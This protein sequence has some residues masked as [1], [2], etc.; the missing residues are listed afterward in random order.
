MDTTNVPQILYNG[1]G[2]KSFRSPVLDS[3]EFIN[4][5][6]QIKREY[7]IEI[8]KEETIENFP[9]SLYFLDTSIY[10]Y[11]ILDNIKGI[12]KIG[13]TFKIGVDSIIKNT[14]NLI[15]SIHNVDN[16]KSEILTFRDYTTRNAPLLRNFTNELNTIH[17]KK[18]IAS[19]VFLSPYIFLEL[20]KND[21]GSYLTNMKSISDSYSEIIKL[22]GDNFSLKNEKRQFDC[23]LSVVLNYY[24]LIYERKRNIDS[25]IDFKLEFLFYRNVMKYF[26]D[27]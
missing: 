1:V 11:F 19:P 5:M 16:Q 13:S 7:N 12:N 23:N 17:K 20:F 4:T 8:I 9:F 26:F 10:Y 24:N 25:D 27:E 18:T 14:C 3:K 2:I 21:M 15:E 22:D 6:N